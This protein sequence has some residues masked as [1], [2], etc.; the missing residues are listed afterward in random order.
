MDFAT[1]ILAAGRGSRAGGYKPLWRLGDETVVD[2]IIDAA[3]SV[4]KEV[5]VVG[6]SSF[7]ELRAH[8]EAKHP[9]VVLVENQSWRDG[10]FSSVQSG[11]KD[12]A[13]STFIHPADIPGPGTDVYRRLKEALA[14]SPNADVV[15]PTYMGRVGHPVLLGIEAVR[16]VQR[17]PA[18]SQLRY[19][20]KSLRRID[21]PVD[22]EL[23]L[24]D[25]DTK[26]DFEI[27]KTRLFL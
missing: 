11:L 3:F 23:I 14:Q 16:S 22:D 27:L 17:A 9:K 7:G 19:E 6:G 20:L 12:L 13:L 1:V 24:Y 21:A 2:R 15:R 4:C 25:F 26:D 5:R 10:M 8:V 18:G